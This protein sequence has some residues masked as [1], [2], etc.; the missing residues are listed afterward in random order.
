MRSMAELFERR[1][2][3]SKSSIFASIHQAFLFLTPLFVIGACALAV[4]NFP[5][6]AVRNA[7]ET[8]LGGRLSTVLGI[9][10]QATYG[11]ASVYLVFTLAYF[12]SLPRSPYMD[13]RIFAAV[14][15]TACYFAFLGPDVLYSG[16]SLLP[17]TNMANIF[18]AMLISLTFTRLF[19]WFY[20]RFMGRRANARSTAFS[21]G[22]YGILPLLVCLCIVAVVVE[23]IRAV[24]P[25]RN[26]NDLVVA[27][28]AKPFESLGA[29]YLGG[30]MVLFFE[31]FL[32]LFSIHG[33]N[34]LD[35][36]LTSETGA[37]AFA[38]GQIV[39]KPFL[40]TYAL[41]G[42]CG[43][44]LC[45]LLAVLLFSRDGRKRHL[46]GIAGGT[47]LFNIN[48]LLI[49]GLPVVLNPIYAI[50]FTLASLAS[51]TIV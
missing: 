26:F 7:V 50:P 39:C 4:Q 22:M 10:Y 35:R 15:S 9:L 6:A 13:V 20:D 27:L 24:S 25:E 8:A 33:G 48:E 1:G 11:F 41:L 3:G 47:I 23:T 21:R 40:D 31:S 19:H 36:L 17:Y 14:S 29:G 38:N 18:S 2:T 49:F 51:Y 46:C 43:M 12:E 32:W 34:V 45:L 37:F 44:T 16:T 28:L 5:A 42:G 30:A